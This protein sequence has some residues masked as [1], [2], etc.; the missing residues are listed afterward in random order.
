[1]SAEV[2]LWLPEEE[3]STPPNLV[4]ISFFAAFAFLVMASMVDEDMRPAPLF[5]GG[6]ILILLALTAGWLKWQSRYGSASLRATT[7]LISGRPFRGVIETELPRLP[8]SPVRIL[9]F[10][11]RL[12]VPPEQ[13]QQS[14][15]GR[16]TIPFSF[17]VPQF[18]YPARPVRLYVRTRT[19]PIGWGATFLFASEDVQFGP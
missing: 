11:L 14:E 19:W 4:K 17:D 7:G 5:V 3:T 8:S 9:L 1:M 6:L 2:P 12:D 13:M 16:I 10:G 18:F 15:S